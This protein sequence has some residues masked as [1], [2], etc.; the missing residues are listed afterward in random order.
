MWDSVKKN[1]VFAEG[2]QFCWSYLDEMDGNG[3]DNDTK[4]LET[5]VGRSQEESNSINEVHD[6]DS[7][8]TLRERQGE[9][10]G[11][12][13]STNG[14]PDNQSMEGELDLPSTPLANI[15]QSNLSQSSSVVEVAS[16]KDLSLSPSPRVRKG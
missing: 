8:R 7:T 14:R 10:D 11:L 2:I 13:G 12:D 15:R 5:G 1:C 9:G 6:S 16:V 3:I 4:A